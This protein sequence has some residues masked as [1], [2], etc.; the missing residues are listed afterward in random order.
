M[1]CK[2]ILSKDTNKDLPTSDTEADLIKTLKSKEI[3]YL[4]TNADI[5]TEVLDKIAS[6][7]ERNDKIMQQKIPGK[8][9]TGYVSS[10][11]SKQSGTSSIS[12]DLT[13]QK[14]NVKM[15]EQDNTPTLADKQSQ[16]SDDI[17]FNPIAK[18]AKYYKNNPQ[19]LSKNMQSKPTSASVSNNRSLEA[20]R[21]FSSDWNESTLEQMQFPPKILH[22]NEPS[23][24][25][26]HEKIFNEIPL[27]AP[28][29]IGEV[30]LPRRLCR[31]TENKPLQMPRLPRQQQHTA[32]K[33]CLTKQMK[34]LDLN[35]NEA[36]YS[37]DDDEFEPQYSKGA[38]YK[39][40]GKE[41]KTVLIPGGH[42]VDL[43]SFMQNNRA[44]YKWVKPKQ[45]CNE[46][47]AGT[48]RGARFFKSSF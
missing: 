36:F 18:I 1:D 5:E 43:M 45:L 40:D 7:Y 14:N 44:A 26:F 13:N 42:E 34:S 38:T 3:E 17:A 33:K 10:N 31:I 28:S 9:S 27:P 2:A 24:I 21:N 15:K 11:Q 35:A 4:P 29:E 25:P 30:V 12:S 23:A 48:S 8:G 20:G 46:P 6:W 32:E 47:K 22:V 39:N 16:S 19:I 37:S 41:V